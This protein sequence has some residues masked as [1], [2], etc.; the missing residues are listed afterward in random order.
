AVASRIVRYRTAVIL[1]GI[2]ILLGA[3]TEGCK[4]ITGI[5][6]LT[7]LTA[8]RAFTVSVCAA[9]T[10]TIM[11]SLKLPVSTTQAVMGAIIGMGFFVDPAKIQWYAVLKMV[12]CWIGTP[13]GAALLAFLF[14]PLF[15]WLLD[16]LDLNLIARS[17]FLKIALVV[18]GCYGA[19]ALGANNVG[20]VTGVYYHTGVL[21][22]IRWLALIGG[23][24]IALGVITYSKKVMLTVG[25]RLVQ[26]DAFSA[27]VAVMAMAVTVHFYAQLGVPVSTSQAIVGAVLGIGLFKGV[28][29]INRRIVLNIFFGW[30]CTPLIAGLVCWTAARIFL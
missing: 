23:A 16:K 1:A 14:Y 4:S 17:V 28:K 9:L 21:G 11:T 15:A 6:E 30:L 18:C 22:N 24:S 27:L 29:T 7:V 25:S 12:T 10:V 20:N 3:L 26:L 13:V 8:N 5:G 2:F 19:Y